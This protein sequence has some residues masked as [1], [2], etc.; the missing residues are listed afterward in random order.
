MGARVKIVV[1]FYTRK[2]NRLRVKV[3]ILVNSGIRKVDSLAF[4]VL[5]KA[6][7]EVIIKGNTPLNAHYDLHLSQTSARLQAA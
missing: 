1:N 2:V 3:K 4:E 6:M 5:I 7:V